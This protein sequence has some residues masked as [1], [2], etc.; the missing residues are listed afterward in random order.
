MCGSFDFWR[1]C[2]FVTRGPGD[3]KLLCGP[4][5]IIKGK[6][7]CGSKGREKARKEQS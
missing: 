7:R 1:I 2:L 4:T 3:N 6:E 5:T